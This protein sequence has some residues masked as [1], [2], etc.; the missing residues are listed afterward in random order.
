MDRYMYVCAWGGIVYDM[1]V[2]VLK[3]VSGALVYARATLTLL[4]LH[5]QTNRTRALKLVTSRVRRGV[6]KCM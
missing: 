3:E 6:F 1:L 5:N 4:T 2:L